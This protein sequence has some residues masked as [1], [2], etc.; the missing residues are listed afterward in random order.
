MLT[1]ASERSTKTRPTIHKAAPNNCKSE[2]RVPRKI[3]VKIMTHATV[4]QSNN[5]TLVIVVNW[6]ALLTASKQKIYK[7]VI[8]K[9]CKWQIPIYIYFISQ[10]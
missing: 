2:Y 6:K 9:I 8:W 1:L 5:V 10:N 4:Q 7:K 3:R